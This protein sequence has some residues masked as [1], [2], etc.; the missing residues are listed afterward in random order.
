MS[1]MV[2]VLEM[3]INYGLALHLKLQQFIVKYT[4]SSNSDS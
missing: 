3:I 4:N 1:G 2:E